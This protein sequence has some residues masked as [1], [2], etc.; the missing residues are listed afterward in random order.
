MARL[1]K[2]PE[3]IRRQLSARREQRRFAQRILK[4]LQ[5]PGRVAGHEKTKSVK[6]RQASGETVTSFFF[7]AD[8][9]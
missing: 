2:R 1:V 7:Q 5:R 3:S 9:L 8:K 6:L 4:R